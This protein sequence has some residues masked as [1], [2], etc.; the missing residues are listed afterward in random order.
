MLRKIH[1]TKMLLNTEIC[2]SAA[3]AGNYFEF[4]AYETGVKL[5]S[6]QYLNH[7]LK[8]IKIIAG[9]VQNMGNWT[10]KLIV[11]LLSLIFLD[12]HYNENVKPRGK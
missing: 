12:Q 9:D 2:D 1:S 5:D 4:H 7:M 3:S 10:M 11:C 8:D 6:Q